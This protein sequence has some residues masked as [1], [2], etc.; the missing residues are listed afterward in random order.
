MNSKINTMTQPILLSKKDR[1]IIALDTPSLDVVKKLVKQLKGSVGMF[2]IGS[3]LFTAHGWA[4]V[5]LVRESGAKIFLDLKFHDIPNT[6]SKTALIVSEHDIFMFNI[7]TLGGLEMMKKTREV[8]DER[9]KLGGGEKPLILG[10]TILTSHTETSLDD[11]GIS[12]KLDDQVLALAK[13]AKKAGLDG[14]VSSARE[15]ELLRKEFGPEFVI[16]TPGIR[17]KGSPKGDQKRTFTPEDAFQAGASYI[18]VG[19]PVTA[20]ENPRSVVEKMIQ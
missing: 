8:I 2:K 17:P 18:V 19:R 10:V 13:L 15:I 20:A 1:L 12:R 14:V 6:V 9:G 3:E 4:A 16:V 11:I 5:D 7:H